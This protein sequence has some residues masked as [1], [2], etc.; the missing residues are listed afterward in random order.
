[1]ATLSI[2]GINPEQRSSCLWG[3]SLLHALAREEAAGRQVPRLTEPGM[4]TWNRF[5]GR[6][7]GHDFIGLLFEDAAVQHP[8]PFDPN[9]LKALVG[10]DLSL[11][12]IP[13]AL[14][15][16]WLAGVQELGLE[17]DSQDYIQEMARFLGVPSRM[18][19]A[20]L[21]V[22]KPHHKVLELPGT[23]GQL[24][25]YLASTHPGLSLQENFAV[26]CETWKELT[27]AGLVALDLRSPRTDFIVQAGPTELK[28]AEHPLR[29]RTYDFVVGLHPDK[30]G[31]FKVQDQ[32]A[33]WFPNATILLV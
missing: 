2:A 23:G 30:G 17:A 16:Q 14:T 1:M 11:E 33:I 13:E 15:E 3:A 25:H 28:Q 20:D 31:V 18:A 4:P 22:V 12:Q 21:H 10:E 27:L 7:T 19:R 29:Q 24:A 9:H 8:I 32:L 6:L 5:R 26:A